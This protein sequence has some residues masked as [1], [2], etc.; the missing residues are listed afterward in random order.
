[1]PPAAQP[2]ETAKPRRAQSFV[3]TLQAQWDKI[4]L[5]VADGAPVPQRYYSPPTLIP[6]SRT[7]RFSFSDERQKKN[8][9]YHV[10]RLYTQHMLRIIVFSPRFIDPGVFIHV[11]WHA[12]IGQVHRFL[13]QLLFFWGGRG[14]GR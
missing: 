10:L 3:F 11:A 13:W 4:L 5:R 8:I 2:T 14:G 12:V 1:M 6:Y 9:S 7:Q